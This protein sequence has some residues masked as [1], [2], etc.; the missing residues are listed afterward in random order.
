MAL[1][2]LDST[3]AISIHMMRRNELSKV[4][5]LSILAVALLFAPAQADA[6]QNPSLCTSVGKACVKTGPQAPV[7]RA[8]VCWNQIHLQL[9]GSGDCP[10]GSWPYWVD[11][12]EVIDPILG[13]VIAYVQLPDACDMGMCVTSPVPDGTTAEPICC[14]NP[15][16]N[17]CE[18]DEGFCPEEYIVWCDQAASNDDGSISCH[19]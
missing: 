1:S 16:Q 8:D 9:K 4:A 3:L 7:L 11:F 10:V 6:G 15:G 18:P 2:Q 13:L 19:D 5:P 17:D 14:P 12:G